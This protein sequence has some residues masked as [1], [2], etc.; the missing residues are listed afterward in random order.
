MTTTGTATVTTSSTVPEE[1]E[2]FTVS[3]GKKKSSG[4]NLSKEKLG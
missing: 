3:E 4:L 2:L 1:R